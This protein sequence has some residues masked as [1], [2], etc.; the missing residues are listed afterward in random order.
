M[1]ANVFVALLLFLQVVSSGVGLW[2]ARRYVVPPSALP[3]MA[4]PAGLV[5]LVGPFIWNL[6]PFIAIVGVVVLAQAAVG[7]VML[8]RAIPLVRRSD[9]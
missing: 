1:N 9:S 6:T 4:T 2:F 3:V 8:T 5:A 7:A